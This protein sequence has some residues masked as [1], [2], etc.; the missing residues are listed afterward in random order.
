MKLTVEKTESLKG[1]IMIPG[2]KSHTIRGLVIATLAEGI[3]TLRNPL[4]SEDTLAAA[5]ACKE[6][7]ASIDM[8]DNSVWSITGTAGKLK[9]PDEDIDLK[10]S[11]TSLRLLVGVIATCGLEVTLDGD[12]SLRK[13][14]IQPLLS[15]LNALGAEALSKR[16]N[17]Y[18]PVSI[19]GRM[20]GGSVEVSGETSQYVSS[21]L[22]ACPLLEGDTTITVT[23]PN[24]LPYVEMTLSWLKEQGIVYEA[25]EDLTKFTIKGGQK[26]TSFDKVIP[27]DWSSAAFPIVAAAITSSEIV[28]KGLS[29]T[30][31]Q[32]DKTII[33]YLKKMGAD[34]T[35]AEDITIKGGNLQGVKLDLNATPDALPAMAVA[36]CCADGTTTLFNVAQ[37]RIKETDRIKVIAEELG[38]L[39]GDLKER[40]DGLVIN[41]SS[42]K[43]SNVRGHS[44]HRIVMAL[45]LAGLV[46]E[47]STTITSAESIDVTYPSYLESMKQLGAKF[48]WEQK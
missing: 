48:T 43:G 7:G 39:G 29:M 2:S 42:F 45:S 25:S 3:S 22:L 18:C 33:D 46:A 24:E 10:N 19:S 28:V 13:R 14:P 30:D 12:E 8:T 17:G 38:K 44:D 26:Y 34:I 20:R 5:N 11:G 23:R 36:G 4:S 47:G 6:L 37:A 27:G 31:T 15:A 40:D 41:K 35:V 32:G 16:N 1:T 9:Q 21:L